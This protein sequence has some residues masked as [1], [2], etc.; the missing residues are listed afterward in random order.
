MVIIIDIQFIANFFHYTVW[1]LKKHGVSDPKKENDKLLVVFD[2]LAYY[3][4]YLN[5]YIS[6]YF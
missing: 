3:Y 6:T 4:M 2:I 5:F 1:G